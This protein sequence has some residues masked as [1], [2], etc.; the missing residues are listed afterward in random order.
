MKAEQTS[1]NINM[2]SRVAADTTIRGEIISPNDIRIDGTFEGKLNCS[3]RVVIGES[4][5]INAEIVCAN[6]DVWGN[7]VGDIFVKDTFSL[8]EGGVVTGNIQVRRLHIE[9][10]SSFN[11]NC[12]M[13]TEEEFAALSDVSPVSDGQD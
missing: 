3:G 7:I 2:V 8:K 5:T 6:I 4:A 1:A 12:R 10:S 9:L 11:G 13:I